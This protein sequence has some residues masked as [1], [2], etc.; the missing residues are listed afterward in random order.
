M[1]VVIGAEVIF[2][3]DL[4]RVVLATDY[5]FEETDCRGEGIVPLDVC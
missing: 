4:A 1:V 2:V 5:A 3:L